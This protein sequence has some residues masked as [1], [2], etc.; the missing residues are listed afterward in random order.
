[1]TSVCH[2]IWLFPGCWGQ[3][4]VLKFEWRTLHQLSRLPS[5]H[6]SP[7]KLVVTGDV[8]CRNFYSCVHGAESKQYLNHHFLSPGAEQ[9]KSSNPS[10]QPCWDHVRHGSERNIRLLC[11]EC[12]RRRGLTNT[13]FLFCSAGWK[14][15][16]MEPARS[17]QGLSLD[18]G[19]Y[20][21]VCPD[22]V[23]S[24]GMSG[25][26]SPPSLPPSLLTFN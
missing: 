20:P 3:T 1:M 8:L 18:C 25:A 6:S 11:P 13:Y 5:S 7:S 15:K 17:L 23:F 22:M 14:S 10:L 2:C 9:S 21:T 12:C 26:Y 16:S 24:Q 4:Q 19:C